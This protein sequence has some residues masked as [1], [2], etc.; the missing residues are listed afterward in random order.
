MYNHT[1][2]PT[3]SKVCALPTSHTRSVDICMGPSLALKPLDD[4][5]PP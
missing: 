4:T 1:F 5:T 2:F 3:F